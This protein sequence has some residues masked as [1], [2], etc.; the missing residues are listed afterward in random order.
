[1]HRWEVGTCSGECL[2]PRA[3]AMVVAMAMAMAT[4]AFSLMHLQVVFQRIS[5]SFF[6]WG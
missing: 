1:M 2:P 3:V 4:D 6:L 5:I